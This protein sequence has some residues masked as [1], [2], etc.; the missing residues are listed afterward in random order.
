M[1]LFSLD[2]YLRGKT[3]HAEKIRIEN[4]CEDAYLVSMLVVVITNTKTN[5]LIILNGYFKG[6]LGTF[7]TNLHKIYALYI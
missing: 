3:L 1:V 2:P 7:N 6:R 5:K 4:G